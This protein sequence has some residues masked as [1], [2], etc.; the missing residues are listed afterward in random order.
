M[1]KMLNCKRCFFSIIKY[2]YLDNYRCSCL[3]LYKKN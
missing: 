3:F 1:I 2:S